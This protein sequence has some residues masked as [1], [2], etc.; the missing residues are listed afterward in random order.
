MNVPPRPIDNKSIAGKHTPASEHAELLVIGGG[1]AGLSAAIEAAKAGLKVKLVDENPIAAGLMGLDVPLLFGQRMTAAVQNSERMLEQIVGAQPLI[2][3]AFECGVDVVLGCTA[4]GAFVNGPG[5]KSLPGPVV[6]LADATRSWLC[7]FDRLIV[8]T[9]ARDLALFFDGCDQPGVMGAQ[10]L[11]AL[12]TRYDAFSGRRLL[13]L[14]SGDL[15]LATATLAL[16]RGLEVVGLVEPRAEA[17]TPDRIS[18][19]AARLP[20]LTGHVI[21]QARHDAF[22]VTGAVVAPVGGGREQ[23]IACDT[24]CLAIG[25]VPMV[26]LLDVLGAK[27]VFDNDRGM[28]V[29]QLDGAATSLTGIFAA[30]DC[31]GVMAADPAEAAAQGRRASAAVLAS[32]GRDAPATQPVAPV[33]GDPAYALD[34]MRALV[35]TGGTQVPACLCEEV[36]RQDLVGVQ[37]P[38]YLGPPPNA[39]ARRNLATLGADGPLNPDQ[40][41]RLTR[42]GMGPCQGRRCREQVAM[43]M[44]LDAGVSLSAIPMASFRAP[45]RPLPLSVLTATDESAAMREHWDVWFGIGP[46]WVP[47]EDIGT[48]REA[49]WLTDSGHV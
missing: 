1:P 22:G 42:A 7:G 29:P 35:S 38:R 44:A 8:A 6:G 46:Q 34:W 47:Y 26:E 20:I 21:S 18:A 25:R 15:A 32:L 5:L 33:A 31:T 37:P 48:E 23:V 39:M 19:L 45:V 27:I 24:I 17:Q 40:V 2:A 49:A 36:T 13:I 28:H 41:K 12:L 30:G 3:E 43:L 10:A 14:G 4:W 9:G 16:A 11:H